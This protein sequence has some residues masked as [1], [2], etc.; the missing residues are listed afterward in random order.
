MTAQSR[1]PA[2]QDV[3]K[4]VKCAQVQFLDKIADVPVVVQRQVPMVVQKEVPAVPADQKFVEDV[5]AQFTDKRRYIPAAQHRQKH[6]SCTVQETG[7]HRDE[8]DMPVAD[9]HQL[10][11]RQRRTSTGQCA[12]GTIEVPRVRSTNDVMDVP[13]VKQRR[14]STTTQTARDVEVARVVPQELVRPA[15]ERA[16]VRERVRQFEADGGVPRLSTGEVPRA[17]PDDKWSQDPEGEAPNKRRKQESDPDPQIPVHFS[18]CDDSSDLEAKSVGESAEF[19]VSRKSEEERQEG[20]SKKL[21]DVMLELRDVRSDLLQVRELVGVLVRRERCA[22]VKTEVAARRLER[23]ER[24]KD[25]ADDAEHEADLQEA[26]ENQTKVVRL[27]VDK[28]FVDQQEKSSSST[29]ASCKA[30]RCFCRH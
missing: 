21:D 6:M 24:E 13:A 20:L 9:Q 23:M 22:E 27:V 8:D 14:V 3:Q 12:Q 7:R 11:A 2:V 28:W 17:A 4:T 25:D 29:P 19:D 16:S 15:G 18:L 1:A 26:L 5:Q 10:V 30:P